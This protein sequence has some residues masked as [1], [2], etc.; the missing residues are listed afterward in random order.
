MSVSAKVHW[1]VSIQDW[2]N[3]VRFCSIQ[4]V[5]FI[6]LSAL[7][8]QCLQPQGQAQWQAA[9]PFCSKAWEA[10]RGGCGFHFRQGKAERF[11]TCS[12]GRWCDAMCTFERYAKYWKC[13]TWIYLNLCDM[14]TMWYS[15]G[16]M[17]APVGDVQS[18]HLPR[19]K[20]KKTLHLT[21]VLTGFL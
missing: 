14:S 4:S 11:E 19:K 10:T 18:I 8:L 1:Y 7:F 12:C 21:Q 13:I 15:L 6:H 3:A 5:P 9:E 17:W 20:L 2:F 16:Y